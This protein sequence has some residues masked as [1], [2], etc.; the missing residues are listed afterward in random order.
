MTLFVDSS[1]F[2]AAADTGDRANAVA[3]AVLGGGDRLV[4]SD[5]VLVE[6]WFLLR[7]RLGREVAER[8]WG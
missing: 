2:Y 8:W 1:M 3:K 7:R 4:T 6:S 5:H